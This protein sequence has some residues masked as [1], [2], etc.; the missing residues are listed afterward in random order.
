MNSSID[1]VIPWVDEKDPVWESE[2]KVWAAKCGKDEFET[3]N[4]RFQ[5]WDNLHLWFRAIEE[6]MPWV[7]KIFLI[8]YGHL[9]EFL[10]LDHPKLRVVRHEEFIPEEY[11]PTFNSNTIEMNLHR[12]PELSENFILF[13]DDVFPLR[14]IGEEY[15][16]RD[17]LVCDE[18]VENIITTSFFGA[19]SNVTRYAQV[20][21]MFIINR[22]FKKREVQAQNPDKW[23][24]ADYGDRLERTKACEYWYDFPGFYDPHM[25]NAMKK[26]VLAHLWDIEYAALDRGSRDHFRGY[27]DVTQY[28]IRYWQICSG[29][30]YPRRTLGKVLFPDID[31]Y[32]EVVDVIRNGSEQMISF[33]ENCTREEFLVIKRAVNEA[34][35]ERFHGKCSYE[36]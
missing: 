12:I 14:H 24:C 21:N 9:P 34:L 17:N 30:F 2:R 19:V 13:S 11:R 32:G 26:S 22:H 31:T 28:L 10:K 33:N 3:S 20:N 35:E 25:A 16:F 29:E 4:V 5:C 7:N 27:A 18:A 23:F 1:I 6:C 15:Y 36:K 8:T